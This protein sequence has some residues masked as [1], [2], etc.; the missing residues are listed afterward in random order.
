MV[1]ISHPTGMDWKITLRTLVEAVGDED[2]A[3]LVGELARADSLVRGRLLRPGKSQR[4]HSNTDYIKAT[5]A[6]NTLNVSNK[7]VYAHQ[8]EL[9]GRHFGSALRFSRR[10]V[11]QYARQRD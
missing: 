9:G 3:D 10:A 8:D 7:F 5:E 4:G 2:L 1:T 6:A 11:E